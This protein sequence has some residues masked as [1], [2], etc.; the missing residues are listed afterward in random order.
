[1]LYKH[2]H[3]QEKVSMKV[4]EE[5]NFK[6]DSSIVELANSLNEDALNKMQYLL[7]ALTETQRLYLAI[8]LD[9]NTPWIIVYYF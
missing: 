8:P 7:A 2:P 9:K 6:D 3:M 4:R 1:M 5:A